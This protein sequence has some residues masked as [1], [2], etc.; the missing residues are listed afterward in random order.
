MG[1]GTVQT[2]YSIGELAPRLVIGF[3]AANFAIPICRTLID[4]ANTITEALTVGDLSTPQTVAQLQNLIGAAL[5]DQTNGLLALIAATMLA[6]LTA[7]L[8]ATWL[9]RI[10][11]LV[12]L[13]GIAPIALACHATP[14]TDPAARLWWRAVLGTLATVVLQVLALSTTMMIFL[15]PRTNNDA[16]GV[17]QDPTGTIRLFIVVCLLWVTIRIP[18]LTH[19]AGTS[20]SRMMVASRRT[21]TASAKP[22]CLSCSTVVASA[23]EKTTNMISEAAATIRATPAR[24]WATAVELSDPDSQYSRMCETM[25]TS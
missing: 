4:S 2:R 8:L 20:M 15:D 17:P 7:M 22:I 1:H 6:V 16:L 10:G 21:A 14:F 12:V 5:G 11:L 3:I 9:I 19:P 23:A 25:N 18:A 13:V 24:P